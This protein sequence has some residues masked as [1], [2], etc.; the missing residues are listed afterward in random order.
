M[1]KVS[2][3]RSAKE[4]AIGKTHCDWVMEQAREVKALLSYDSVPMIALNKVRA[5]SAIETAMSSLRELQ[6]FVESV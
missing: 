5:L 2:E 1:S 6:A 4:I 3:P